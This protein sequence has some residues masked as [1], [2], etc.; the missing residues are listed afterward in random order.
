MQG[1]TVCFTVVLPETGR[2]APGEGSVWGTVGGVAPFDPELH[3]TSAN[4]D[5]MAN[6]DFETVA[7]FTGETVPEPGARI[8]SL[9]TPLSSAP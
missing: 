8:G 7:A 3:A 1:S 6:A 2:I 5:K 9:R 4:A